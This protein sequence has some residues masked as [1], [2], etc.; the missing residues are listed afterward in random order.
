MRLNPAIGLSGQPGSGK[1]SLASILGL[2]T[3]WP[4][5]AFG[6]YLR[7]IAARRGLGTDRASLQQLGE[8]QIALGWEA[9]CVAVLNHSGWK[10]GHGLVVDGIRHVDAVG[11][12]N[13]LIYPQSLYHVHLAIDEELRHNRLASR[14]GF[15]AL[16]DTSEEHST[17]AEVK[18]ALP[19]AADM[20]VDAARPVEQLADD[21]MD[22]VLP[23]EP[24]RNGHPLIDIVPDWS[25]FSGVLYRSELN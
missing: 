9:F 21:I 18:S 4:K 20:V 16:F 2:R 12:L 7:H 24:V 23:K 6:D 3:S 8:E 11:T 22:A 10:R 19:N 13:K 17:E 1:S 14:D 25:S 15:Q 5:A